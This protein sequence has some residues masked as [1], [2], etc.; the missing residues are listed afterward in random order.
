MISKST[1]SH[2]KDTSIKVNK[3]KIPFENAYVEDCYKFIVC[4]GNNSGLVRKALERRSWWI[5]IQPVHSAYNFKWQ[6]F[7]NGIKF[8]RLGHMEQ[9]KPGELGST[10]VANAYSGITALKQQQLTQVANDKAGC[11]MVNHFEAHKL[12][13][14]KYNLLNMMQK[15]CDQVK[16]NPFE[17]MPITFYVEFATDPQKESTYNQAM[18]HFFQVYHTLEANKDKLVKL[19]EQLIKQ[20]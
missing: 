13:T 6:P 8:A 10:G 16:E 2:K 4:Y 5:E 18:Q 15:F 12:L 19:R 7:S 9:A 17:F 3:S 20:L 14:E 1:I 11:Q